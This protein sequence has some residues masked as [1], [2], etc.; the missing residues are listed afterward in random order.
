MICLFVLLRGAP[1][2]VLLN[3]GK[4]Y[5]SNSFEGLKDF[6]MSEYELATP[7]DIPPEPSILTAASVDTKLKLGILGAVVV[8][9][10]VFAMKNNTGAPDP[11]KKN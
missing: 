9:I 1:H 7:E 2:A 6:A 11:K 8:V 5:R 3:K 10:A 4:L